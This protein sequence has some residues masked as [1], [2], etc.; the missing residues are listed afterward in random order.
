[1]VTLS[2]TYRGVRRTAACFLFVSALTISTGLSAAETPQLQAPS[3][4]SRAGEIV[5]QPLK[6]LN[7]YRPEIPAV[8]LK[9]KQAP[10][11]VPAAKDCQMLD[12]EI[13]ELDRAL[14]PDLD[15]ATGKDESVSKKISDT[16]FNL[17]RGAVSGLVPYRG[18][19]RFVTGA[20][21]H[22][23]A[24]NEALLAGAVRRSYLKGYG[25]MLACGYPAA[26]K[27]GEITAA[28]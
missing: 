5:K 20:E 3:Q 11:A 18:V 17:A 22:A 16:S 1:M 6:D 24:I 27:R 10:Y 28:H 25:E 19:V 15:I 2:D 4:G 12:A 8:L 7:V 23:R 9:A 13:A 14:G 21:K 26:P